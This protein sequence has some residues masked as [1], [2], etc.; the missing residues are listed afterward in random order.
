MEAFLE[1]FLPRVLPVDVDSQVRTFE[2][3]QDLEKQLV[4]QLRAWRRPNSHFVVL[5]D[6]DN[7]DCRALKA[8]LAG[9]CKKAG[10]PETLVRVVCRELESWYLGDLRAVADY[11]D[12]E[13]IAR[14]QQKSTFRDP[15][16]V[17]HP[18][19]ALQKL[20]GGRYSKV[21]DSRELGARISIANN[22]SPSLAALVAGLERVV[23]T[24]QT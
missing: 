16:G 9:I 19:D 7:D 24:Q 11:F 10:R 5:R 22:R 21:R 8:K 23:P 2:G 14:Q 13:A 15:D 12:R 3:K 1:G 6:Q 17:G 4:A 18:A 20:S